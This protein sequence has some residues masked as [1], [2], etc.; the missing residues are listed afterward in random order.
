MANDHQ[1]DTA[2]VSHSLPKRQERVEQVLNLMGEADASVLHM[3]K[4]IR[5]HTHRIYDRWIVPLVRETWPELLQDH[6]FGR[7]LR[8]GTCDLY[9]AAPYTVLMFAPERPP[10]FRMLTGIAN[11]LPLPFPLLGLAGRAGLW[12]LSR[13][14]QYQT[15]HRRITLIGAFVVVIDHVFDHC[16]DDPPEERGRKVKALIN[17]ELTPTTPPLKLAAALREAMEE[18]LEPHEEA[19]FADAMQTLYRW[20]EAEVKGLLGLEDPTG[21]GHRLPG[22]EGV[23]DGL[24]VGVRRYVNDACRNWMVDVS[25][26]IQMI[27][28]WIDLEGDLEDNRRTLVVTGDWTFTEITEG[29]NKTV[30]GIENLTRAAGLTS[31]HYVEFIRTAYVFMLRELVDR[32]EDMSAA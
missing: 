30:R 14:P 5:S 1:T 2:A 17:Q 20:V 9:A 16:L 18:G 4:G 12:C 26:Y 27:D 23:I 31:P 15:A 32:M 21:Y 8:I 19:P 11:G 28:D 24:L 10:F 29:W 22:V 7:K 25:I 6:P 13:M 3:I